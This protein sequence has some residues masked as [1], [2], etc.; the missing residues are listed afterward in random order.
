MA[1]YKFLY[2]DDENDASTAAIA[3]GLQTGG[4]IDVNMKSQRYLEMK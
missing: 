3:D 1:K 4:H 2:L